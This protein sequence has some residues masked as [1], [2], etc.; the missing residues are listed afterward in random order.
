MD[1][2]VPIQIGSVEYEGL[3]NRD[4]I[5]YVPIYGLAEAKD[6]IRG[7]LRYKVYCIST[8]IM[9]IYISMPSPSDRDTVL[10]SA[11]VTKVVVSC[12]DLCT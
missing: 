5:K 3:P 1:A 4:S 6:L 8:S 9:V 11:F 10:I 2:S 7:S 12:N